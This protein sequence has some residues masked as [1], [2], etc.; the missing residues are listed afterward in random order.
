MSIYATNAFLAVALFVLLARLWYLHENDRKRQDELI[1][2]LYGFLFKLQQCLGQDRSAKA[3][4]A[5]RLQEILDGRDPAARASDRGVEPLTPEEVAER[6]CGL[7][8]KE[9]PP[10]L[11]RV[12]SFSM[13]MTREYTREVV[14]LTDEE[15]EEVGDQVAP[16]R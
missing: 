1:R 5:R 16:A 14:G 6:I 15:L 4:A 13:W 7:L 12:I 3:D 11:E 9:E 2:T 10:Q 8:T